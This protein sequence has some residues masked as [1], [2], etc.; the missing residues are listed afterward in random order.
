MSKRSADLLLGDMRDA[1]KKIDR[2]IKG[3]SH[4]RFAD[5]EKTVDAV[6]RN[7]EIIGE[8]VT[9]LPKEFKKQHAGI[10]WLKIAGLRHRIVHEYF[11]VDL[12]IIWTIVKKDLPTFKA[13]LQ[14]ISRH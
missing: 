6:A 5:D 2:Y 10:P 9:R 4:D 11:G 8:A 1:M 3:M 14:K 13:Q 12:D 7:L